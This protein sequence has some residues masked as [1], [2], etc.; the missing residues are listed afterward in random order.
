MPVA[1]RRGNSFAIGQ[2]QI[3]SIGAADRILDAVFLLTKERPIAPQ[4]YDYQRQTYFVKLVS[5]E[6]AKTAEFAKNMDVVEKSL[7]TALQSQI[8]TEW[9]KNLEKGSTIKQEI[10]FSSKDLPVAVD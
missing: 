6:P 4:L 9:I 2:G 1:R 10:K 5:I 3:P 8:I 7:T